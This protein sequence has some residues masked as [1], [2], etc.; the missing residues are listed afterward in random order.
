MLLTVKRVKSDPKLFTFLLLPNYSLNH[1]DSKFFSTISFFK[2]NLMVHFVEHRLLLNPIF[3]D[4][5]FNPNPS[6]ICDWQSNPNPIT[7]QLLL[8]KDIGQQILNGQ[9]LWFI[10]Y[11]LWSWNS[12]ET[13]LINL[14]PHWL[15][16]CLKF[17]KKVAWYYC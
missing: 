14:Q 12:H 9:V 3:L 1:W 4:C 16:N 15:I 5:Q 6:Q 2:C 11:D 13:S 8:E 7:I 10:I 17:L